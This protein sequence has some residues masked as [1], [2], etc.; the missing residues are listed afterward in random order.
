MTEQIVNIDTKW[1]S[2]K[3]DFKYIF[4]RNPLIK[5]YYLSA[6]QRI[7]LCYEKGITY[8]TKKESQ[9]ILKQFNCSLK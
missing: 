3:L 7:V 1:I 4:D 8:M 6:Q 5:S 9:E 2:S